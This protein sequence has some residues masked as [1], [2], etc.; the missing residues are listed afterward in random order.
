MKQN[1][2]IVLVD[3]KLPCVPFRTIAIPH[4]LL[5]AKSFGNTHNFKNVSVTL[6]LSYICYYEI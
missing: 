6:I 3:Q 1:I 4:C 2:T 5:I